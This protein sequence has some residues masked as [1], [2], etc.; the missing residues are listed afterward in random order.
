MHAWETLEQLCRRSWN[1]TRLNLMA[2]PIRSAHQPSRPM[3][4]GYDFAKN[5][6]LSSQLTYPASDSAYPCAFEHYESLYLH[7]P[8][9][10]AMTS[11]A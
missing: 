10:P 5:A 1:R 11:L 2:R 6:I 3:S 8:R 9:S 7:R 4:A